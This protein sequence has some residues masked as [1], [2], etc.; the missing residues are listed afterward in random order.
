MATL[1]RSLSFFILGLLLG[2]AGATTLLVL[3]QRSERLGTPQVSGQTV[4]RLGHVLDQ[5][6]P[7]HAGME[8]MADRLEELS[9]GTVV[10]RIFPNGQLGSEPECIEQVQRGVLDMV[11]TSAAAMEGFTP[12]MA[13]FGLP[14]LFRNEEHYWN[15]LGGPLGQELLQASRPTGS[16]GLCYYDSG[17]RSFYTVRQPILEPGDVAGLKLRV[18]PSRMAM[19][20]ISTFG[21]APTPIPWG[22]LYTALQQGMVDGAENNPPSLLTSRHYEVAKHYSLNEHTRVPD[23]LLVS[24]AAWER[25]PE[26][27]Q[28]W[29]Q[30][31]AD[32]SVVFQRR[33]WA[34]KTREAIEELETAGVQVYRPDPAPFAEA[35]EPLR[36]AHEGTRVGELADRIEAVE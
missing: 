21:G 14:Y 6:H 11:K 23:V 30:Q 20:M 19:D 22:E 32:D 13:V 35:A 12:E 5:S 28:A 27:V 36:R 16:I 31:A 3:W 29:L 8:Y 4:L 9:A 7:V 18:L 1:N 15:V 24:L 34:E 33:L 17:S 2:A 25:L 10:I 26:H